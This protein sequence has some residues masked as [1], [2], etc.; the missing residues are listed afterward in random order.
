MALAIFDLDNTLLAADSDHAWGQYLV[1]R[2]LVDGHEHQRR[3]DE[4]YQ[5]YKTGTLN[6]YEYLAF[7]L[8]PLSQHPLPLMLTEREQFLQERIQ[9]LISQKSRDLIQQHKDAGDTLLI[10]TATNAF[11]TEPIAEL[12]GIEHLIAPV[13][14]MVNGAYTG[15]ITGIPSFQQG[16]VTRL[17]EWLSHRQLTLQGSYFYSDSHND[18]PLLQEVDHPVAVDPDDTL[19]AYA[20]QQGWPVISLCL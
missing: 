8:K 20:E 17:R 2:K 15:N 19:K 16:K 14:E 1:D 7:A 10:I 11:V 3:N 9:P 12:L 13:P 18:L 6:I 5:D 4:F